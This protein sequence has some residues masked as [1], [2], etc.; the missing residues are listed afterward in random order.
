MRLAS[1]LPALIAFAVFLAAP[2]AD[3]LVIAGYNAA[4]HERFS[5][6]FASSPTP[7]AGGSF[8][9]AGLDWS[10]VGWGFTEP[11]RGFAM[12]SDQYFAFA[13]HWPPWAAGNQV[14]FYSPLLSSVVTFTVDT[15][16]GWSPAAF[17]AGQPQ[18]DLR[19]GRLA[20]PIPSTMG[21]VNYPILDLPALG[22]YLGLQA[23][24]YGRGASG[25]ASPRIGANHIEGFA[26][27][28]LWGD[29]VNDN[30][31]ALFFHDS[32]PTGEARVE[33]GD[34]GSPTFVLVD[35]RLALVGTHAALGDTGSQY[36]TVDNFIPVFLDQM[37]SAGIPFLTITPEPGRAMLLM[38]AAGAWVLRRRRA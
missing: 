4:A 12:I 29:S 27:Y 19:I 33:P 23:L 2:G 26:Y 18:P 5:S 36:F 32:S 9:G 17:S 25:S 38:M 6:G 14:S 7:N 24:L 1:Q 8:I 16:F 13:G 37:Q 20:A 28:D 3:A 10:G 21:I 35:G 34:S 31:G 11:T 30:F 15:G 22:N